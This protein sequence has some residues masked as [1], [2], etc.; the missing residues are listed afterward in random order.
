M[1][2]DPSDLGSLIL[3][4]ITPK[5]PVHCPTSLHLCREFEKGIKHG[6][7][8]SS[9]LARFDSK[10]SFQFSRLVPLVSDRSVW[11]NGKHPWCL[12]MSFPEENGYFSRISGRLPSAPPQEIKLIFGKLK[13]YR[14]P[15]H[16]SLHLVSNGPS[17]KQNN[18]Y[19]GS[20]E[21]KSKMDHWTDD[22]TLL[23]FLCLA[24]R[25]VEF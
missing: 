24:C 9:W 7:S 2:H 3:I 13:I 19:Q 16:R 23:T 18:F 10:M 4:Q 14:Y 17:N 21:L 22:N 20:L 11:H 8:H 5:E 12:F 1:H 25:I 6:K 15:R